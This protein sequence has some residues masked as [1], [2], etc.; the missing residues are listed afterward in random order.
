MKN[1][2]DFILTLSCPDQ[3]GI[4]YYITGALL[5]LS[6]NIVTSQQFGDEDTKQFF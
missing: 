4:V 2:H 5:E 1:S 3:V 6:G